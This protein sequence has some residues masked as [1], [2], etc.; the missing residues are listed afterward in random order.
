MVFPGQIRRWRLSLSVLLRRGESSDKTRSRRFRRWLNVYLASPQLRHFILGCCPIPRSRFS[1]HTRQTCLMLQEFLARIFHVA[2]SARS[3]ITWNRNQ[4]H[5]RWHDGLCSEYG[6]GVSPRFRVCP[7]AGNQIL[8][9]SPM[10]SEQIEV[11]QLLCLTC[12]KK[13]H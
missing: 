8:V 11:A 12:S 2:L 4:P 5:N 10:L 13:P 3:A 9:F 1:C 7:G 6:T